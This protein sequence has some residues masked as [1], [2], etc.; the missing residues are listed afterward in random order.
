VALA[1]WC[2]LVDTSFIELAITQERIMNIT[3]R[4]AAAA[5]AFVLTLSMLIGVDTQA[6]SKAY[7]P[8]M[9]H[10]VGTAQA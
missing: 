9:A 6:T 10:A 2:L 8:Q 3:H 4:F 7:A 1:P 5:F